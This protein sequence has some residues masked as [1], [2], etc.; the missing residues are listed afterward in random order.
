[1]TTTIKHNHR[2]VR[3]YY[4]SKIDEKEIILRDQSENLRRL[5]A[6]RNELNN[7]G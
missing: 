3:D 5:E 4:L 6:Q 1:M 2:G 7:R